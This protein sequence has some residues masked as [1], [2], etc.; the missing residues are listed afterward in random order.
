MIC[1]DHIYHPVVF[2]NY[3]PPD[4]DQYNL[5]YGLKISNYQYIYQLTAVYMVIKIIDYMQRMQK[6][7]IGPYKILKMINL[8]TISKDCMSI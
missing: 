4:K 7:K 2:V 8:A 1:F 3:I 5:C 6:L